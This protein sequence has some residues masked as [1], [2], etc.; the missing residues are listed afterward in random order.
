MSLAVHG[1]VLSLLALAQTAPQAAKTAPAPPRP[2]T[3]AAAAVDLRPVAA[4]IE[5][6]QLTAAE[7]QLRRVLARSNDAAARDLLGVVLAQQGRGA[8]AEREFRQ[9]IAVNPALRGAHQHLARLYLEQKREAEAIAELRR[10]VALGPLERDLGLKL[11]AAELAEGHPVLAERQL[12]AVAER[13][14]SVTAL[15]E[16]AKLQVRQKNLAA[17]LS[18]LARARTLAPNSEEALNASAQV[19]LTMRTPVPALQVLEPLARICPSVAQYR[20]MLGVALM[21]AGDVPAATD[22][23]KEAERLDPARPS[24]LFALGLVLNTQKMYGEA[25]PYLV[26]GLALEP[27]SVDG[28]AALAESE[29]GLGELA[30]AEEHAQRA[31]ARSADHAIGNLALGMVRM[32]QERYEEACAALEKAIA[33]DPTSPKTPYQLSLAWTR[34]G[35]QA[36][37]KKY[38]DLYRQRI[39]E[40]DM[41]LEEVRAKT[42]IGG[43]MKR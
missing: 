23:L 36:Q 31:L 42:G 26:R 4:L 39:R 25:R 19:W 12:R 21:Q 14:D 41:R 6:G 43:G 10:A 15:M 3:P 8:E 22:V 5:K 33:A 13:Y 28:M 11:A 17:A 9:A 38:F 2:A 27:D 35:D 30:Q 37:A 16:L 20:Y 7:E 18:T 32:K 1:L 24:T 29:E 34:R 40:I